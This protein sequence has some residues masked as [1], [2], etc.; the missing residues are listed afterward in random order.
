MR[1]PLIFIR[2]LFLFPLVVTSG[3]AQAQTQDP[4]PAEQEPAAPTVVPVPE[5][6]SSVAQAR[7]RLSEIS[8]E[9]QPGEAKIEFLEQIEKL[10][11]EFHDLVDKTE[12][13]SFE[14]YTL[15]TLLDVKQKWKA[16][17]ASLHEMSSKAVDRLR[18]FDRLREEI[19]MNRSTWRA[20]R[21]SSASEELP[22]ETRTK[23][24][25]LLDEIEQ[26]DSDLGQRRE[27]LLSVQERI[28]DWS[29]TA[30]TTLTAL[31][32]VAAEKRRSTFTL[33]SPPLWSAVRSAIRD[34]TGVFVPERAGKKF[35]LVFQSFA[36]IYL[37][38]M[39]LHAVAL[40]LAIV[41]MGAL[42]RRALTWETEDEALQ[43]ALRVSRRPV[44][45][46]IV[47]AFAFADVIYPRAQFA[48][49]ELFYVLIV[50]AS[51]RLVR[52]LMPM[53]LVRP[54]KW[55][56]IVVLIYYF[57]GVFYPGGL[58][59]RLQNLSISTLAVAG[60]V[61]WLYRGAK[62]ARLPARWRKLDYLVRAVG[63]T[64]LASMMANVIG[65]QALADILTTGSISTVFFGVII[66]VGAVVFD[67][68]IV[69]LL[70]MEHRSASSM[71]R[72]HRVLIQRRVTKL[73]WIT[74]G[75]I[76]VM[77]TLEHFRVWDPIVGQA[78]A[79]LAAEWTA[80]SITIS[81]ASI[82]SFFL[83]IWVATLA[84]RMIRFV[85]GEDVLP[86]MPLK[87]G[88]P[89]AILMFVNY[90]IMTVGFI[91][92]LAIL[93]FEPS[94]FTLIGGALGVGL[95][96]G[97]QTL[98]NNFVS[99]LILI[100]ERPIQV[101]DTV[102]IGNLLGIVRSIGIRASVIQTF[103]GSEVIVP[104][105][106]LLANEV[107]NW[108][109]SDQMRRL[110]IPVGV[111]YGSNPLQVIELL[112]E[113]AIGQEKVLRD[114][115]PYVLFQGFGESSLD[116]ELRAWTIDPDWIFIA[117]DMK[118]QVYAALNRAGIEIPFPQR[119]LHVRSVESSVG[120]MLRRPAGQKPA[121]E[122]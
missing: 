111:A 113:I 17:E 122:D 14:H 9:I 117:S 108:T 50:L 82:V 112:K 49:Y 46:A 105:G 87:R 73:I 58:V 3:F 34:S 103:S 28:T 93:G 95:G 37:Q 68:T 60:S 86:R 20:T 11:E 10:G 45:A 97:L 121:T 7:L 102:E 81:L 98:V 5:I 23:M 21:D 110:E 16:M 42:R 79:L 6:P 76:W 107:I 67:S 56:L 69:L 62:E 57:V 80:G 88:V 75:F 39:I 48:M 27:E 36:S 2:L 61:W 30:A 55:L 33:D 24:K 18:E 40:L 54:T 78:R 22:E 116:F 109:L 53:G 120:E 38:R 43:N 47:L 8:H 72:N 19:D 84:S 118:V 65:M 15:R 66:Y 12:S 92:A 4:A 91:L 70:N 114:P 115:E 77:L 89:G 13:R 52:L 99:G 119:D 106:N 94:Q 104:N 101:G 35:V 83:A 85:L 31:E 63:A 1:I 59:D 32:E 64:L 26:V 71:I 96:F 44:A 29:V 51:L 90:T 25:S 41:M 100:F 74:A